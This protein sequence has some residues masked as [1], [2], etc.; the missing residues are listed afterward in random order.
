MLDKRNS[1]HVFH[2]IVA[3]C[4]SILIYI[5]TCSEKHTRRAQSSIFYSIFITE[6]GK[7]IANCQG[8]NSITEMETIQR[9]KN[10]I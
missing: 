10:E 5:V 8:D 1:A 7:E 9:K 6:N 2:H 3:F 4:V